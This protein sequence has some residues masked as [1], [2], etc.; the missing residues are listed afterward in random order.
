MFSLSVKLK[1]PVNPLIRLAE[2]LFHHDGKTAPGHA[3]LTAEILLEKHFDARGIQNRASEIHVIHMQ[4]YQG[5]PGN[6]RQEGIHEI[7]VH[8]R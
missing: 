3:F 7:D 6:A 1:K 4:G 5:H 8:L 2:T